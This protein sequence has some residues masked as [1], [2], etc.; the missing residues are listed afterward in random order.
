MVR[1]SLGEQLLDLAKK[2][3]LLEFREVPEGNL[4]KLKTASLG[5]KKTA[6]KNLKIRSR[7]P[8]NLFYLD[9][10]DPVLGPLASNA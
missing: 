2:K 9:H 7:D 8:K 10:E 1:T 3:N 5:K 6:V 4:E